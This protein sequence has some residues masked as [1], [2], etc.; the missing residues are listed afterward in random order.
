MKHTLV[1]AVSIAALSLA[2]CKKSEA[3]AGDVA[4]TSA[5]TDDAMAAATPAA[6][7]GQVFADTAAAS[8]QFEIESS[9]L[10]AS[11]A[12]SAKVKTFA[13]QMIKAHTDSTAKLK[14]AAASASPAITPAP[15]LT[16]MQQQTLDD[17]GTKSGA[18]FDTAYAKAQTDAH[19]MTLDTLKAYSASGDVPSLKS[20]ATTLVPI[21]TAH[22]NMAKGL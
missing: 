4:A 12:K 3:P 21:V 14:A 19:Q 18:E 16:A 20:F 6:T 10:A 7:P 22:L 15:K 9:K 8:D 5:A 17:L 11:K 1:L 13:E 2:G